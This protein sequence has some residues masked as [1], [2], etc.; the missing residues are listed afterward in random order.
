MCVLM[1]MLSCVFMLVW[2]VE[3]LCLCMQQ[4]RADSPCIQEEKET[5]AQNTNTQTSFSLQVPLQLLPVGELK[6]APWTP[7]VK[8]HTWSNIKYRYAFPKS[9]I[10][11]LLNYVFEHIWPLLFCCLPAQ[12]VAI[13]LCVQSRRQ[14]EE[15]S[16]CSHRLPPSLL[17]L[18]EPTWSEW[19]VNEAH[20]RMTA[21]C[22]V[23]STHSSCLFV[24]VSGWTYKQRAY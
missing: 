21:V 18:T 8:R 12:T 1:C 17:T 3:S 2:A 14:L 9:P 13:C 10:C 24:S 16:T 6:S 22:L 15:R 20:I 4:G 5:I 19:R 11:F 23:A 7:R